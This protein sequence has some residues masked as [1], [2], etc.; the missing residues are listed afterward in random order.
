MVHKL[1]KRF[2]SFSLLVATAAVAFSCI[3]EKN[4]HAP[5]FSN[6]IGFDLALNSGFKTPTTKAGVSG[7]DKNATESKIVSIEQLDQRI[8]DKKLYLH[9]V[10]Q[11]WNGMPETG[12]VQEKEGVNTKGTIITNDGDYTM[13][14]KQMGGSAWVY[15]GDATAD[16][17]SG[18]FYF[19]NDILS[20]PWK[21]TRYWPQSKDYI[22][23]YAY[24]PCDVQN[25][26]KN[27]GVADY[28]TLPQT[29]TNGVPSFD[30]TV[31]ADVTEQSDL[32]V[33]S[34]L[35]PNADFGKEVPMAFKHALTAVQFMAEDLDNLLIESIRLTGLKN[36]GTYTYAHKY[37]N[38]ENEE[39]GFWSADDTED[40]EYLLDFTQ[41][42]LE[43]ADGVD[44]NGGFLFVG[45]DNNR[46]TQRLL[47]EGNFILFL[48]PQQ[49]SENATLILAGRDDVRKEPVTLQASIGGNGKSWQK[50]Q[51]VIYKISVS[52]IDVEYV[53]DV[54]DVS[55]ELDDLRK[56]PVNDTIYT[57][58]NGHVP[59]VPFYGQIGRSFKVTSYKKIIKLGQQE[60]TYE[61]LAWDIDQG[62]EASRV[63]DWIDR[64]TCLE[65]EGVESE[66]A[67]E[68]VYY[69]VIAQTPECISHENLKS[70]SDLYNNKTLENAYDLSMTG[71]PK[72]MN[73]ANCYIVDAPGYYKL[74][75]VYGN[76]IVGGNPDN[77]SPNTSAY[78]YSG[79]PSD[80]ADYRL[81]SYGMLQPVTT[82][83][84]TI[85]VNYN[86][87]QNFFSYGG[88]GFP[89]T[90]A[91]ITKE[92]GHV[93]ANDIKSEV[94]WQDEPCVIMEDTIIDNYLYFRVRED[95]ICECNAVVAIKLKGENSS[96]AYGK[97]DIFWSWH[98]WVTD[99][100]KNEDTKRDILLKSDEDFY[101]N[102]ED[103]YES[104]Y[105][106]LMQVPL[107]FCNGETKTYK[108]RHHEFTFRQY[109]NGEVRDSKTFKITQVGESD[110]VVTH[111][112]NVVYYQFG[113]KD[114]IHSAYAVGGGDK[115][116]SYYTEMRARYSKG[117]GGGRVGFHSLDDKIWM[118]IAD[119]IKLPG[120]MFMAPQHHLPSDEAQTTLRIRMWY[121]DAQVNVN[122]FYVNLWNN[123]NC[124]LPMFTYPKSYHAT[125]NP[126]GVHSE[127]V[128][129]KLTTLLSWGMKKTI[130]D[131]SPAGYELPMID[132]FA[133]L[134]QGG[135][136]Y[137]ENLLLTSKY[138]PQFDPN[139][140]SISFK[141]ENGNTFKI[142][143]F[144]HRSDTT[145]KITNYG[146]YG[147]ALTS[148]PVCVQ[149][150]NNDQSQGFLNPYFLI[151]SSRLYFANGTKPVLWPM[152]SSS[153][154]LAF[155][156]IPAVTGKNRYLP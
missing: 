86:I 25:G 123:N 12:S 154:A 149:W 50:G 52:D 153:M 77:P 145:G 96:N 138:N 17:S 97:G 72:T 68:E 132:A 99:K 26:E 67:F 18:N 21:S 152:A 101:D 78:T 65:G 70:F 64:I 93:N 113:R 13:A 114:P 48:M 141:D 108:P 142:G 122:E 143:A 23:F 9:T 121:G 41:G 69:D 53:F 129:S 135:L 63:P 79:P 28:V 137:E 140:G 147:A 76:G 85:G 45:D 38:S 47:N 125:S 58:E 39:N 103:S 5:E 150:S 15:D 2:S 81:Y 33:S 40:G 11:P 110:S 54:E 106:Q 62:Q 37:N 1:L 91:W 71:E 19:I 84:T 148:T 128:Y 111:P 144:G 8:G 119:G 42:D 87:M 49:L 57:L 74:P 43:K 136:N 89:I 104:R 115:N 31:P 44:G 131:P 27:N 30:F 14:D 102:G 16:Y 55:V 92:G 83:S 130:Y 151:G 35:V 82:E 20:A 120:Q 146:V 4:E 24:A 127:D 98:I 51:H 46:P 118:T 95:C 117:Y 34:E 32:L 56:D 109:E 155:P 90:G 66:S 22:L 80:H 133:G 100:N 88:S 105:F 6:R 7:A 94:V 126:D 124:Q 139:D 36:N 156:V 116:K 60:P 75:L 59:F 61:K 29:W 107:G 73:T 112:D 134:T 3:N 10:S